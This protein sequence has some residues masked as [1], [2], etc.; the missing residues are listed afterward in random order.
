MSISK[1]RH[2]GVLGRTK[3]YRSF[4]ADR[5]RAKKLV[6]DSLT[7]ATSLVGSLDYSEKRS[8]LN[9]VY[10]AI[11][12]LE[13]TNLRTRCTPVDSKPLLREAEDLAKLLNIDL[14]DIPD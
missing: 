9:A 5:C 7:Y 12:D 6:G 1:R 10:Y 3:R 4:R 11:R 14:I 8:A 2:G 13:A